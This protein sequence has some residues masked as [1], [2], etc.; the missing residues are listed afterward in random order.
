MTIEGAMG[1]DPSRYGEEFIAALDDP[2]RVWGHPFSY[3][4]DEAT[5]L[6][7]LTLATLDDVASLS[8]LQSCWTTLMHEVAPE[9]SRSVDVFQQCLRHSEGSFTT[10]HRVQDGT[11]IEFH[12]PSIKDYVL[13]KLAQRGDFI[14]RLLRAAVSVRQIDRLL[15][16][17]PEGKV[18]HQQIHCPQQIA[19]LESA[20]TT[21]LFKEQVRYRINSGANRNVWFERQR[22]DV[23]DGLA[24][25][26]RWQT[27]SD[28]KGIFRPVCEALRVWLFRPESD[29]GRLA[30]LGACDFVA[31]VQEHDQVVAMEYDAEL[32]RI[33]QEVGDYVLESQDLDTW[34][35]WA[36]MIISDPIVS[37]DIDIG[38]WAERAF[39][40]CQEEVTNIVYNADSWETAE[41]T[42][43]AIESL[44]QKFGR[45]VEGDRGRLEESREYIEAKGFKR[46]SDF[47]GWS[48]RADAVNDI[49]DGEVDELFSSLVR[50]E[51]FGSEE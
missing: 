45:S 14:S 44:A 17:S 46:R 29:P 20:I 5:R 11:A 35:D 4:I 30:S 26:G 28:V 31:A 21:A 48:E 51:R 8:D 16:L 32:N 47:I 41:T 3:Q 34:L 25:I 27:Q 49:S 2:D 40:F 12:N 10:T 6:L 43:E 22:Q 15:R 19:L 1:S 7:L 42:F 13:K 33:V 9:Q 18:D 37:A 24:L 39:E 36:S 23:G 50:S 38:E